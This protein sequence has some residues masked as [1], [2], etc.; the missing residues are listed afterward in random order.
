MNRR[1][2]ESL[3]FETYGVKPEYPWEKY[4]TFE[5][6]RHKANRKWFAVIM[7]VEKSK[8]GIKADGLIDIVNLK[9][10]FDIITLARQEKGFFPAYHM[11]KEH[12]LSV[13]L[14]GSVDKEKLKFL[15]GLSFDL[16]FAT[17]K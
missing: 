13:A 12:W 4:P 7:T 11:N 14:D 2:F 17:K 10:D 15:L 6:Y 3:I 9:S 8:I 16:T 5:V 1:E